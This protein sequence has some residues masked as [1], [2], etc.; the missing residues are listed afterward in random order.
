MLLYIYRVF[1]LAGKALQ[2]I[3]QERATAWTGVPTMLND[4]M[5]VSHAS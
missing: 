2:L 4:L 5:E 1:F 3:E